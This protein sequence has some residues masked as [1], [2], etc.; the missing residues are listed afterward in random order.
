[1]LE[2]LRKISRFS[3]PPRHNIIFLFNGAEESPLQAAHGFIT[4]HPWAK[5]VKVVVNL[6]AAGAGG[7]IILFQTGP[8]R[9]WL[10]KYYSKVPHPIG[11]ATGEELFQSGFIPSDTDFRVFRDFGNTIG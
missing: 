2:V 7:K 1:M 4:Q 3:Q 9:P 11:S 5:S 8:N 6:E 10:L